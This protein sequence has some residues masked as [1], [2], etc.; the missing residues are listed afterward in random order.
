[1]STFVSE[2]SLPLETPKDTH[3]TDDHSAPHVVTN[4]TFLSDD[5]DSSANWPVISSLEVELS[6]TTS[7]DYTEHHTAILDG[8]P[9]TAEQE[10]DTKTPQ[11]ASE[12]FGFLTERRKSILER[13][14]AIS[15]AQA[16]P[17]LPGLA[18]PGLAPPSRTLSSASSSVMSTPALTATTTTATNSL[19]SSPTASS[20]TSSAQIHHATLTKVTPMSRS[21]DNLNILYTPSALPRALSPQPTANSILSHSTAGQP[22]KIPRGPR[23]APTSS[24]KHTPAASQSSLYLQ[25]AVSAVSVAPPAEPESVVP[26]S[27][28]PKSSSRSGAY[29]PYT[30]LHKRPHRRT[31]SR[32]SNMSASVLALDNENAFFDDRDE[33]EESAYAPVPPP[34]RGSRRASHAEDID[35]EN[36]PSAQTES[37]KAYPKTPAIPRSNPHSHSRALFDARHPNLINNIGM[38]EPPSPAKSIDLSPVAREMMDDVRKRR[39]QGVRTGSGGRSSNRAVSGDKRR[40]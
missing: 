5:L 32:T 28:I 22:S 21:T 17:P 26:P 38:G 20:D 7:L 39:R 25:D 34:K 29:D 36:S 9:P 6:G 2:C 10:M 19:N 27:R 33:E 23:P 35:K 18:V 16:L 37:R 12:V 24:S 40:V 13:K 31:A 1:M 14:Q 11:R 15:D 4:N 8:A 30:P 3:F